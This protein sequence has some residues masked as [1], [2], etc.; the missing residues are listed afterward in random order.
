[1]KFA[2]LCSHESYQPE[3]LVEQAVAA[4]EAGF[5]AVLGSD[6]FH[7]WVDD[8]SAAGFVW[9]WLGAVAVKTER[10]TLGTSVTCPLFHYHP[11]LVAQMAATTDRLSNGRLLLGVGTGE[12]LNERSLG[13]PFP[14]YAERQARM[15]ESLEIMHRMLAGEKVTFHG[16]Y[17][18]TETAKLYSPPKGSVPI[19]M[20]AGGPKSAAFAGTYADGLITSVKDPA[21]TVAKVIGPYRKAATEAGKEHLVLATRWTV[22]AASQEEAWRHSAPCA[23]CAPPAALR[24]PTRRSCGSRPTRWTRRTCCPATR[25]SPTPRA[26]STPTAP[27]SPTSARTSSRSR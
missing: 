21:D 15:Q 6:H 11:G 19:L 22:L 2:W 3:D 8:T 5:D 17:Y 27:W 13:F 14:G 4:E 1:M 7:P 16:E 9:S 20:A 18:T 23:A 25:S 12:A 10:V 26:S 24:P